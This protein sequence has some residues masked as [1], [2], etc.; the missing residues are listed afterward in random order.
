MKK[1]ILMVVMSAAISATVSAQSLDLMTGTEL[2]IEQ[3]QHPF[4]PSVDALSFYAF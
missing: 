2:H 3:K 1:M 4:L